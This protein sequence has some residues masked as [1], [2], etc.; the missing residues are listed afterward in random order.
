M[1]DIDFIFSQWSSTQIV[2][3]FTR[4][5]LKY[6]LWLF[7]IEKKKIKKLLRFKY[8]DQWSLLELNT[9]NE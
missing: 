8:I 5:Y 4:L 9:T 6:T 2:Q 7:I 1:S 3:P